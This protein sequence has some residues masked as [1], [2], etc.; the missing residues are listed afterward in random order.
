MPSLF[1][2][3]RSNN[4][5]RSVSLAG[6][7][8][9]A[10]F[11]AAACGLAT[12][13]SPMAIAQ[14]ATAEPVVAKANG[15]LLTID[16]W[17]GKLWES[18]RTGDSANFERLLTQLDANSIGTG[19]GGPTVAAAASRL[20]EHYA[21]READ[22]ATRIEEVRKDLADLASD[23]PLPEKL[24][25]EKGAEERGE[26]KTKPKDK[27]KGPITAEV[28]LSRAL[29]AALELHMLSTD[30]EAVIADPTVQ[31][32]I[33]RAAN[34]ARAAEAKGDLLTAGE[35]FI[36]LDSL[37]DVPGTYKA[38]VRR[39]V[40][41]Q[42]MLR[43][44]APQRM[45]ELGNARRL[46]AG[47]ESL[48]PYNPFG[49]DWQT[50]LSTVNQ[51]LIERAVDYTR[52][53][54][55]QK[56]T[57]T[58][59]IGGL[60]ALKTMAT[61]SDLQTVFKG[62][63]D[64]ELRTQWIATLDREAAAL[65]DLPVDL[66]RYQVQGLVSRL[67]KANDNSVKIAP[68]AVLHEFGNGLMGKLDEFSAIIWPDELKRFQKATEGRFV[69]VGIQIEYDEE[70]NIRVVTPLEGTP[71]QRAGV[72]PKDVLKKV[73]GRAIFGFT[74]D[75][76]VE[77]ITGPAGTDVELTLDRTKEL[78]EGAPA[79]AK[80]EK[81]EVVVKLTR[82]TIKVPTAKG[83]VRDGIQENDWDYFVDKESRVGYIRLSQFSEETATELATAA[84]ELKSAGVTGLILD[85][86]FNPGGLLDQAV[87]VA[88]QFIDVK[89]GYI[90][91][92]QVAGGRIES[93]E[94]TR[95]SDAKL[96]HLPL[97]VLVNEGSASASEIVSGALATYARAGDIDAVVL[98]SRSY[99]KGSVQ[100]VWQISPTAAMKVTTAH[101]MLPD[102]SIIH[103]KLGATKWGIE[104][105]LKVEMLPKQNTDAIIMRRNADIVLL[106]EKGQVV[107]D[108]KNPRPN[109]TDLITKGLDLQLEAAVVLL[110][111]RAAAAGEAPKTVS[112]DGK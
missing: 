93:P 22:R 12:V 56:P 41:R 81:E 67:L 7:T 87:K 55:D 110:K 100:N 19:A 79:D 82:A 46:A 21:K 107:E 94:F 44:Y 76:A 77:V 73:D 109:P 60:D 65:K 83:F 70:S 5:V 52:R 14:T 15:N 69:G 102:K 26:L 64:N 97:V 90:V 27:P 39:I 106:N 72:H 51:G 28:R 6:I 99:G 38:D 9:R 13:V 58:L 104:P 30:K 20:A 63:G 43:L 17:S 78:P 31:G 33:S 111:A 103:R 25:S 57:N 75:Q 3:S 89:D 74:L 54:V 47:E 62:I 10:A 66:D 4:V 49:D 98:G 105:N 92:S 29:R 108:A 95:P 91:M 85:L 8:F 101:Y 32:L 35:L 1:A 42:E 50:K 68:Q 16:T 2:G 18:A 80:P 48:P 112:T 84:S 53:H 96:A 40:Q 71:A 88:R 34:D 59:L 23:K 24:A 45:W 61:T 36:L 37:L 11:I 86:R